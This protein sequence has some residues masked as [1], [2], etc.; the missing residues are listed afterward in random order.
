MT[1][2]EKLHTDKYAVYP[3][4]RDIRYFFGNLKTIEIS[5]YSE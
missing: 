5:N 4:F 3:V 2:N 1:V